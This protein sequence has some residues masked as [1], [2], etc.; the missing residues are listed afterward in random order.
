MRAMLLI[1]A[2]AMA[3]WGC[4]GEAQRGE[5]ATGVEAAALAPAA[6]AAKASGDQGWLRPVPGAT[7][8]DG[9]AAQGREKLGRIVTYKTSATPAAALAHHRS[10]A[11][12]AGFA[13]QMAM[14]QGGMLMWAGMVPGTERAFSVM[15][16]PGAGGGAT[17]MLTS[18]AK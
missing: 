2:A 10:T 1:G 4:G 12:A 5:A 17:V 7:N 18:G 9:V 6:P 11:M 3:L 16:S 14:D 13:Q 15:A 8:T